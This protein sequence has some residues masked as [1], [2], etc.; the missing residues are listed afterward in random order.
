MN[1]K[2]LLISSVALVLSLTA[3][4]DEVM[5]WYTPDGHY[6]VSDYEIPLEI[7]EQLQYYDYIKAY[8]PSG[9]TVG[10]GL[11][12]SMYTDQKSPDYKQ[13]CDDNFQIFTCGNEMKHGVVCSNSGKYNFDDINNYLAK[14]DPSAL[15]YG[16]NFIWHT[17]Q[18][19]TYLKSLIAPTRNNVSSGDVCINEVDNGDFDDQSTS[20][21]MF[22]GTAYY[23]YD[24]VAGSAGSEEGYCLHFAKD[25]TETNSWD[26]QLF[27]SL[28]DPLM[29]GET[30]AYSFYI[31]SDMGLSVQFIGQNSDYSYQIY[32]DTFT[33]GSEW[34]YCTGEFDYASSA[35]LEDI[36]RVGIQFGSSGSD[37]DFYIDDFKFG[38][39]NENTDPMINVFDGDDSN[40]E[41]GTTGGWGSWGGD[42]WGISEQGEG[43]NSDYC[44]VLNNGIDQDAWNCQFAYTFSDPLTEGATYVIKFSAKCSTSAGQLQ[45]QYQNSSTYGDQ[46]G[47]NTFEI[48]TDWA[49]Y[50]YEFTM[51]N[52]KDD[53]II[54]NFGAVAGTYYIDDIKF[55]V[56]IEDESENKSLKATE[57]SYTL[58]SS[59]EKKANLL[60]A[61]EEWISA[62]SDDVHEKIGDRLVAWDVINE[63]IT[64]DAKYRGIDY[65]FGGTSNDGVLDSA[66]V[67]TESDGLNL[68]WANDTGNQHFYWGY[69][70]GMDYATKAFEFA[71]KYNPDALL[72]VNDYNLENSEAKLAKLIEF[73]QY[74]D[75][76]GEVPVDGIGTQMHVELTTGVDDAEVQALN[77]KV[78]NMFR[79]LAATG[80][81][82]RVTEL[83]V[84][85]NTGSPSATQQAYQSD[86][87]QHIVEAYLSIIP[88]SQQSGITFWTLSDAAAEHEYWLSDCAP[89]LFDKN[90][91]RKHAYKGVCNGLA[92]YDI[93]DA[94]DGTMW[95]N[96]GE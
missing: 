83:D 51:P 80:K 38:L 16:H 40:F 30:Y 37:G 70:L 42:S 72:F 67:E 64:D 79:T 41:G 5:D 4:D 11:D 96:S 82:I 18:N 54:L 66:P 1:N 35:G 29:D 62:I 13:V 15:V 53:R 20:G 92:G 2:I 89:N 49:D 94:L 17:Q 27:W 45:F 61:M 28:S 65:Q 74:I 46:G 12:V 69:Y 22:N 33:A 24:F 31:K 71:R 59:E 14:L 93:S 9:F 56:K 75:A 78:D 50:E 95:Y 39:K 36:V 8:V 77:D 55:G 32:K 76:N 10:L 7:A 73:V 90:Y 84:S 34:T 44:V 81:I 63:P 60:V 26:C 21:W 68:N 58:M 23:S 3:C 57:A 43:Y 91:N 6:A 48:G 85:L 87:Y 86:V 47:Y 25:G 19:Q 52:D 88:S